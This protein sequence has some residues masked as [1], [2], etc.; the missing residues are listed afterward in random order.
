MKLWLE[1]SPCVDKV[2]QGSGMPVHIRSCPVIARV[3]KITLHR[4]GNRCKVS[5]NGHSQVKASSSNGC[6]IHFSCY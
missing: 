3:W 6:L 1:A 4:K 5:V 2:I